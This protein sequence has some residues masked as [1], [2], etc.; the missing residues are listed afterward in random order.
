MTDDELKALLQK[1]GFLNAGAYDAQGNLANFRRLLDA[2]A[3][4]II[5]AEVSV[6]MDDLFRTDGRRMFGTVT[7]VLKSP[8]QQLGNWRFEVRADGLWAVNT[9]R[10]WSFFITEHA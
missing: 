3:A 10:K 7:E 2:H 8:G 9:I 4:D 6:D 5:G 1:A